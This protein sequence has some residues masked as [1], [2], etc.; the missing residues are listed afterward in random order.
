MAYVVLH[1]LTATSTSFR[2]MSIM[3]NIALRKNRITVGFEPP[4]AASMTP[5]IVLRTSREFTMLLGIGETWRRLPV[6][7][8]ISSSQSFFPSAPTTGLEYTSSSHSLL[9]LAPG[10]T[11]VSGAGDAAAAAA[12]A[13]AAD[14]A[15]AGAAEGASVAGGGEDG[16]EAS[17]VDIGKDVENLRL[18]C[19]RARASPGCC[20]WAAPAAAAVSD[21]APHDTC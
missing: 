10:L 4:G 1:G 11:V 13:G 17:G 9:I 2:A 5:S 7:S 8:Q 16:V 15:A 14:A 12:A 18:L 3:L 19:L 21:V 20:P 6:E